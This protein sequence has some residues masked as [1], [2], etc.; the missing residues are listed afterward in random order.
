MHSFKMISESIL[1]L[2]K[3]GHIILL[4][5]ICCFGFVLRIYR[6]D[7]RSI[8]VDETFSLFE[9]TGQ[10]QD[11]DNFLN[12]ENVG[13]GLKKTA[14]LPSG[15]Y[16]SFLKYNPNRGLRD[17]L[18]SILKTDTQPPLYFFIM[19][20]WIKY[21]GD[22]LFSI[23]LFSVVCGIIS[24]ICAFFITCILFGRMAGLFSA[25]FI[26]VSPFAVFYSREARHYSLILAITLLSNYFLI[27]FQKEDRKV[28]LIGFIIATALGL[29]IHYFYTFVLL[30]QV[31]YFL[32]RKF[33]PEKKNTFYVAFS[34]SLLLYLPWILAVLRYGYNFKLTEWVFG[35]PTNI[36]EIIRT[37][38][39]KLML[40][41]SVLDKK[42]YAYYVILN[43]S[44]V[45][46]LLLLAGKILFGFKK[47]LLLFTIAFFL[48]I[49]SMAFLVLVE[50]GTLLMQERYYTFAFAAL[51]PFTG[52]ALSSCTNRV[53][54]K[55][56]VI[57]LFLVLI[58]SSL[59]VVNGFALRD[60][61]TP[62]TK[63]VAFWINEESRREKS[64]VV[65][66]NRRAHIMPL[67]YYLD[68]DIL[69]APIN[70]EI[71]LKDIT[72]YLASI[73]NIFIIQPEFKLIDSYAL[74]KSFSIP[75]FLQ[76]GFVLKEEREFGSDSIK[77]IKLS[78]VNAINSN[79][80]QQTQK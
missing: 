14:P 65:I 70:D 55:V 59:L 72:R 67:V 36:A 69:I 40:F 45:I 35:H 38:L 53:A 44:L 58:M 68:K 42:I 23:R 64:I 24:I 75:E 62:R 16:L 37:I 50:G 21:F 78:S 26:A 61:S 57:F 80:Q 76:M 8:W 51:V 73:D 9:S 19:H 3:Y 41:F 49:T 46:C 48:P 74:E 39:A 1:Y 43:Y 20:L 22:T 77:V 13:T 6:L 63:N 28:F 5:F 71:E 66:F 56:I 33:T 47:E 34:I 15:R 60:L 54:Y 32:L 29:Y 52:Y 12:A 27:K 11:M 25:L 10:G 31:I 4:I 30:A 7:S 17:V 2:R 18:I 79:K